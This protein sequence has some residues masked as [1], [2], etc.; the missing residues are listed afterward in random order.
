MADVS[1]LPLQALVETHRNEIK[2]AAARHKGRAVAIFGSVA[3]GEETSSSD[4]DF[5]IEFEAGASLFDLIRV[6]DDLAQLLMHDV[7][8]VDLHGLKLRDHDIR[9]DAR[10]L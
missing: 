9:R 10:W 4:I 2:A 8:V 6:E 5:L 3:R 1:L 7:D